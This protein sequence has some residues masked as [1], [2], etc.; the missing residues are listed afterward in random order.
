VKIGRVVV[1][2]PWAA[3][4][5]RDA[6]VLEVV[7]QPSMGFGTGHHAST[8]LCTALLQELDLV[9]RSVLD[10]GTGSG[11]LALVALRLGAQS[12]EGIDNDA[13]ALAAAT[14]NVELNGLSG[15]ISLHEAD[16]RDLP[17][18][19]ADI[20]TAN[21]TGALLAR[22]AVLL[23]AAVRPGGTLIVSGVTAEEE[24]AVVNAFQPHLRLASR[25]AEDGWVGLLFRQA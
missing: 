23:S 13:D 22:S 25:L 15:R 5:E 1:T 10:V 6:T 11:V 7:I 19:S 20:V 12:V 4:G 8:R 18:L 9:G 2:P 24:A 17:S 14:E 3:D 16:F 21:L